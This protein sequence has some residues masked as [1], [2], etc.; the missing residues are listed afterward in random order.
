MPSREN[1]TKALWRGAACLWLGCLAALGG[2]R[3]QSYLPNMQASVRSEKPFVIA[4]SDKSLGFGFVSHPYLLAVSTSRIALTYFVTGDPPGA[5]K[6][7]T[8]W[9]AYSDDGGKTWAFGDP[10]NWQGP[11]PTNLNHPTSLSRGEHVPFF[12]MGYFFAATALSNNVRVVQYYVAKGTRCGMAVNRGLRSAD[13]G[14]TW[15]GPE[16]IV[17]TTP[18]NLWRPRMGLSPKALQ[19]NDGTL[20]C[21]GYGRL[22]NET[23]MSNPFRGRYSSYVYRSVDEGKTFEYWGTIATPEDVPWGNEGA[24]EP[25]IEQLPNGE[26]IALIRTQGGGFGRMPAKNMLLARSVDQG[27]MWEKKELL[28]GGVMPG[29]LRLQ[30]GVLVAVYGLP[31][32]CLMFSVNNGHGWSKEVVLT[33]PDVKTTGYIDMLEVSPNRL[34]LVYDTYDAPLSKAWLWEPPD[35]V[36]AIWGMF[37]NIELRPWAIKPR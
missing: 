32:N 31:G 34:L 19:L 1:R 15:T 10:F 14:K 9:P 4:Q 23:N 37:I 28:I 17:F 11:T 29:L 20:L 35:F 2:C 13:G 25:T 6:A 21:V 36:N 8:D 27:R 18:T 22:I 26:L 24:C 33:P 16:E 30:N 7:A 3:G 5:T 12:N